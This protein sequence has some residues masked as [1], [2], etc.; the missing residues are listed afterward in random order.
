MRGFA[1]RSAG[2]HMPVEQ[3]MATFVTVT[4]RTSWRMSQE[5]L[6]RCTW[7]HMQGHFWSSQKGTPG[8]GRVPLAITG[9][10]LSPTEGDV[11]GDVRSACGIFSQ[12]CS[13]WKRHTCKMCEDGLQTEASRR[14]VPVA[15]MGRMT[16]EVEALR[17]E[18]TVLHGCRMLCTRM[19]R[20][21]RS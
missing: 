1:V 2:R 9:A 4:C 15:K 3:R 16:A 12:G 21:S 14:G 18:L 8:V 5:G 13:C 7:A 17:R 10:A 6:L 11:A 20:R 19:R